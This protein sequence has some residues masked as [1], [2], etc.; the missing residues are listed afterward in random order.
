MRDPHFQL[1]KKREL[2]GQIADLKTDLAPLDRRQEAHHAVSM[3]STLAWYVTAHN[4]LCN[5]VLARQLACGGGAA[6]MSHVQGDGYQWLD[7]TVC[8]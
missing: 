7:D 2:E 8:Q 3:H 4:T 6:C 1:N 5:H